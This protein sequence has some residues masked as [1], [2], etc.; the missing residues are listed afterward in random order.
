M[1]GQYY[2]RNLNNHQISARL[3]FHKQ[4]WMMRDFIDL[5]PNGCLFGMRLRL[6]NWSFEFCINVSLIDFEIG[7][8]L[9]RVMSH[10]C[11]AMQ[12]EFREFFFVHLWQ[13]QNCMIINFHG[14]SWTVSFNCLCYFIVNLMQFPSQQ[15]I[16]RDYA[17][18]HI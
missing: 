17:K 18:Q 5:S 7:V 8:M 9:R 2:I 12:M 4:N 13:S 11:R 6:S 10:K 16:N 3:E 14:A 15:L 1:I